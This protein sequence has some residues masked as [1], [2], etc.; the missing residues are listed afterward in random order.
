MDNKNNIMPSAKQ[1]RTVLIILWSTLV[2]YLI[3]KLLGGNW[4]EIVCENE[5]FISVCEYMDN[6]FV[7]KVIITF[8]TSTILY[9]FLYLTEVLQPD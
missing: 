4:F 1:I 3:I 7:A 5:R 6:H 2:V 8:I 9:S